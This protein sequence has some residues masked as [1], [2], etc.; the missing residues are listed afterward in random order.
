M[1]DVLN[2][3]EA[4][5]IGNWV[6]TSAWGYPFVL[7]SHAIGMGLLAGMVMMLNLR[8]LGVGAQAPTPDFR[9]LL[10]LVL[11]GLIINVLS[12]IALFLGGASKIFWVWAFWAKL[13]CIALGMATFVMAYRPLLVP[14]R[15]ITSREKT[16]AAVSI[17]LWVVAIVTGRLIAYLD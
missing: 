7:T 3:L 14:G 11:L 4:T 9:R 2:W 8:V 16:L 6:G 5:A 10:D 12:G 1:N 17:A 13:G 15:A